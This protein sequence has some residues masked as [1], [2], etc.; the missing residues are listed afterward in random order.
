MNLLGAEVRRFW[1]RRAV[2]VVLLVTTVLVGLLVASALWSTRPPSAAEVRDTQAQIDQMGDSWKEEI[3]RCREDPDSYL[4]SGASADDCESLQPRVEDYLGRAPLDL[5]Q[6]RDARGL[7]LVVVLVG[8]TIVLAASFTGADWGSGVMGTQLVFEPRRLRMW[9]AK[10]VAVV[11]ST[12]L[13]AAL[14]SAAFWAVLYAAARAR[15]LDVPGGVVTAVL[16]QSA[17]GLALVAAAA[18]GTHALTML[19]RSTV[20]TLGLLFGYAVAGEIVVASLPFAKMSQWSLANNVQAWVSDGVQVY[21]ESTCAGSSGFDGSCDPTY[22]LA[23]VH[24]AAYLA[25]LLAVVVLV[26]PPAFQ[27]RD[28]A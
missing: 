4:T 18:L 17:R 19:L 28:V 2:A 15:G 20:G 23:G 5:D 21:D 24:G 14:L 12:T 25:V 22:L 8:A 11:V 13:A 7:G 1:A 10:A 3:A 6:E 26:S 9:G 16:D 27:R